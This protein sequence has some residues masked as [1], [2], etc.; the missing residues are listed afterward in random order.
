MNTASYERMERCADIALRGDLNALPELF[1][2]LADADW[3]LRYAAA[4][5]LGDLRPKT[6][7]QPLLAALAIEDAAPLY[8]QPPLS[9]G[10]SAGSGNVTAPQFPAGTTE[11]Q[12]AAWT[13]R[14]R[15]K[16]AICLALGAVG[17]GAPEVLEALHRTAVDGGEDYLVRASSCKA[18]GL[19][20]S[21]TSRAVLD[22]AAKDEEWCTA[23][24]AHKALA[25]LPT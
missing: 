3:Q 23:K 20:G 16:Q 2:A 21:P 19:I 13:R 8:S 17:E 11:E 14:G 6:A 5:A 22:Q 12:I 9:A 7:V 15:L 1:S 18:L 25:R 24:E 10:G 4:V